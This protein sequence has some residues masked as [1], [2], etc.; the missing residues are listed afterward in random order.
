MRI[1]VTG[2]AGKVGTCCVPF[3]PAK[4]AP[5]PAP[6]FVGSTSVPAGAGGRA[7]SPTRPPWDGDEGRAGAVVHLGGQSREHPWD[8]IVHANMDGTY[9]LLEGGP[10]GGGRQVVLMGS[11]HAVRLPPPGTASRHGA[12]LPGPPF[13]RPDTF[14]G[15]SKVVMEGLASLPRQVRHER[16]GDQARHLRRGPVRHPRAGHLD[17]TRPT[18]P[19][20][21]RPRSPHPVSTCVWGVSANTRRWW[22]L[23]E[24]EAIGYH[25][26]DD[27]ESRSLLPDRRARRARPGRPRPRPS[28]AASSGAAG[29]RGRLVSVPAR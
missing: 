1:L 6:T 18:S 15:V 8:D 10:E 25:P 4:A 20:W 23:R 13:P 27:A 7:T 5:A 3:S 17:L 16:D 19:G 2:A 29:A 14:Y 24:A 22:S 12:D 28:S 11:H 9:V 21:W 26:E